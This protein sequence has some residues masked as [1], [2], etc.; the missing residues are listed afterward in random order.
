M[1]TNPVMMTGT[2]AVGACF[3]LQTDRAVKCVIQTIYDTSG[4]R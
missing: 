3:P 1:M 2:K 4:I